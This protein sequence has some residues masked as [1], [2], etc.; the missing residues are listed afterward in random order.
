M[1]IYTS[2]D[3]ETVHLQWRPVGDNL[4]SDAHR[5]LTP[6]SPPIFGLTYED[7]RARAPGPVEVEVA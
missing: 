3:G 6:D 4:R 7:W 1:T 2:L 5:A